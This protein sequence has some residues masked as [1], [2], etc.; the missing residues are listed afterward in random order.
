ME[1]DRRFYVS[2]GI[3]AALFFC[4]GHYMVDARRLSGFFARLEQLA[5]L[6]T[7]GLLVP[8]GVAG[9]ALVLTSLMG[10][11]RRWQLAGGLF[12]ATAVGGVVGGLTALYRYPMPWSDYERAPAWLVAEVRELESSWREE[13]AAAPWYR[14]R[15]TPGRLDRLQLS[16]ARVTPA[17]G[18]VKPETVYFDAALSDGTEI[19]G[20]FEARRHGT[21]LLRSVRTIVRADPQR[22]VRT[23][24]S[25]WLDFD[26]D[27]RA[28]GLLVTAVPSDAAD[29]SDTRLNA[30]LDGA[31]GKRVSSVGVSNLQTGPWERFFD[32]AALS[33][34]PGPWRLQAQFVGPQAG[35]FSFV[36]QD[37]ATIAS[38][39]GELDGAHTRILPAFEEVPLDQDGNGLYEG[40]ELVFELEVSFPGSYP[41]SADLQ[42]ADRSFVSSS[43]RFRF[44]EPG[45]HRVGLLFEGQDLRAAPQDGPWTIASVQSYYD[46]YRQVTGTTAAV[47]AGAFAHT[48]PWRREQFEP[49][50]REPARSAAG[51]ADR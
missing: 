31:D 33:A 30:W 18:G 9:A 10:S 16:Y 22:F 47:H 32:A 49:A 6:A 13:P 12:L 21:P 37:L 4:V 41:L 20:Q 34:T 43:K 1:R 48:A 3:L 26:G 19:V 14:F 38:T 7:W 5:T 27:G 50:S 11:A 23:L 35:D 17:G 44:D 39:D 2:L 24:E 29:L 15:Q 40:L 36:L 25:R 51:A 8:L 42:V 28:N 45:R 46:G